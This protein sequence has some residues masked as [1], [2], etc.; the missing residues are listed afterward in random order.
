MFITEQSKNITYEFGSYKWK[1]DKNGNLLD[2]PE[3]NNNH[4]IDAIRYVLES[5]IGLNKKKLTI[6]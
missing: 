4:T 2:V 3:D 5:T 6:L 1:V